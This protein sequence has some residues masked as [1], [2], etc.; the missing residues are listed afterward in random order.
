MRSN[1]LPAARF[2][3]LRDVDQLVSA[4]LLQVLAEAGIAAYARQRANAIDPTRFDVIDRI[5]VDATRH[6]EA[7]RI[8]DEQLPSITALL[9]RDDDAA[10]A[11]IVAGWDDEGGA[12][13]GAWPAQ[14]DLD[15]DGRSDAD[16]DTDEAPWSPED[17]STWTRRRLIRPAAAPEVAPVAA[18]EP[19]DPDEHFVPPPP[20]PLPRLDKP[21]AVGLGALSLGIVALFGIWIFGLQVDAIV[22]WLA[23]F[24]AL[25]GGASLIVRMRDKLPPEEGGPDDGAVV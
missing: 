14:E 10:F 3:V 4:R 22:E 1:G 5:W 21:T 18:D 8:V 11:E 20:P 25:A 16:D 9:D 6:D 23:L 19:D 15:G 7:A 2:E 13:V 17:T 12:P 24:M